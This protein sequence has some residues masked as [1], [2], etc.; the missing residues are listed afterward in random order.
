MLEGLGF[1]LL[2]GIYGV[3]ISFLKRNWETLSWQ[4]DETV[5]P[6]AFP[7]VSVI[8]PARNEEAS[9]GMLLQ[10]LQLQ[11]HLVRTPEII[12]VNDHSEDE[13]VSIAQSFEGVRVISLEEKGINSYKKKAL[14]KGVQ[15]ASRELI[16]CTDADCVPGPD[17]LYTLL[18][19]YQE[20]KPV[21]IAAP[22]QLTNTG[23]LFGKFQTLDFLV[24]QGVT[25]A[26][27]QS[28]KINMANG[29]NLAYP[30]KVFEEVGGYRGTHHL[31][32]GDDFF[33]LHKIADRYPDQVV[34]LKST[35]ALVQTPALQTG[36]QFLH[37]RIRWASKSTSY[38][39]PYLLPV[40][41]LVWCY[42]FCFLLVAIASFFDWR[43]GCLLIIGLLLKTLMEWPF[44]KSVSRFFG[45]P[46]TVMQF[47]CWQ[48]LHIT[49]T[50]LAGLL[51]LFG[52][53][54]WKGRRVQ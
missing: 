30:K 47:A 6:A 17:W 7:T 14:E 50:V 16:V 8:I 28:K 5:S 10:A 33:L 4:P 54:E 41:A 43:S 35:A 29:A 24:L 37:Q 48:P 44:V 11:R 18:A 15:V 31:A 52:R 12:V 45:V 32:S 25:G 20:K 49:Y 19:C 21:F 39:D 3:L 40:L 1:L 46:L 2:S 9:I 22:V 13:T 53:Y 42:N 26:G 34:Y 51:G 27:L 23:S 38:K 36:S